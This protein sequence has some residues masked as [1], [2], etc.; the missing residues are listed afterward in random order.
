M[1]TIP[2]SDGSWGVSSQV[3]MVM[4]GEMARSRKLTADKMPPDISREPQMIQW[5][6]K[7]CIVRKSRTNRTEQQFKT[8]DRRLSVSKESNYLQGKVRE[9]FIKKKK[10]NFKKI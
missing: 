1:C 3:G 10:K 5:N 6:L 7:E 2:E 9:A 8:S 4:P